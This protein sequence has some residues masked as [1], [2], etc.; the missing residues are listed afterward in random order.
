VA[1][2][3]TDLIALMV[4]STLWDALGS[5][6]A[7][8]QI[9]VLAAA[10]VVCTPA[11]GS[12]FRGRAH[13][14][15]DRSGD[16]AAAAGRSRRPAAHPGRSGGA[17]GFATALSVNFLALRLDREAQLAQRRGEDVQAQLAVTRSATA[18]LA[19]WRWSSWTRNGLPRALN[20]AAEQYDRTGRRRR[21]RPR[22]RRRAT[23]GQGADGRPLC[24]AGQPGCLPPA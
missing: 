11:T 22:G 10:A 13:P 23:G 16:V 9:A 5:G 12:G 20:A 1:H 19:A 18:E 7:V 24:R 8:L 2:V 17:A 6:I 3:L 14:D 4:L 21:A 15:A